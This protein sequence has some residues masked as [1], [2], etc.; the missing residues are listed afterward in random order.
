MLLLLLRSIDNKKGYVLLLLLAVVSAPVLAQ[1]S[2]SD[3]LISIKNLNQTKLDSS[4][5]VFLKNYNYNLPFLKSVQFRTESRDL[6]LKRQEYALRVKPNSLWARSNQKK[7][8]QRRIEEIQIQNKI[9]F[10]KTL[11]E[12]YLQV[13]KYIF[14]DKLIGLYR[15]RKMHI[16]DKLRILSQSIY[17]TNFDVKDL[18]ETEEELLSTQLKLS[19]LEEIKLNQQFFLKEEGSFKNG[20]VEFK[21]EDLIG[22]KQI[23]ENAIDDPQDIEVLDVTLQKLKLSTLESEMKFDVA[24]T[25][26]LL[27]YVQAKYGGKNSFLFDENFSISVGINL[28]FFGNK[29]A[30]KGSYY[31][32]RLSREGKLNESVL[33]AKRDER[34][35]F[36]VF[37]IAISNYE[38]IMAQMEKSSVVSLLE[39]YKN[40]EGVSPLILL[41]LRMLQHKKQIEAH[42]VENNLYVKYIEA[43]ASKEVLFQKPLLNYLSNTLEPLEL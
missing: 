1:S 11:K 28:P 38:S 34:M 17:D 22:A 19:N 18:I 27:D 15:D 14:N 32:E 7:I 3:Y 9:N 25:K 36:D 37:K 24:S 23:C 29:R 10:N 20:N 43:L 33:D 6:R 2:I 13:V 42:K 4:S 8:Y 39:V 21:L 26:Q 12:R 30:N 41:K 35:A 5:L 16:E 31:L 40:M